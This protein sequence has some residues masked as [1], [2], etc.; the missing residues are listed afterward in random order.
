MNFIIVKEITLN[1]L[2]E[3][4]KINNLNK[5]LIHP[6][7]KNFRFAAITYIDYGRSIIK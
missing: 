7:K 2:L 3:K 4:D 1:E 6:I 5:H